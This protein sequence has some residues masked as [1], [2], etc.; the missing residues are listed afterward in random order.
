MCIRDRISAAK[1]ILEYLNQSNH[2]VLVSTHDIELTQLLGGQFALY[3]FQE[4][5][6]EEKLSFDYTIKKGALKKKNAIKILEIAGYP[7]A[8]IAEA[9]RLSLQFEKDKTA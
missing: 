4:R 1:A 3:Y 6:E 2:I 5:V 9:E 7:K 8:I